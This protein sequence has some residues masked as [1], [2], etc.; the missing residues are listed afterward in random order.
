MN[1]KETLHD[2]STFVLVMLGANRQQAITSAKVD[3][4][5]CRHVSSLG[6]DKLIKWHCMDT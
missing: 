2:T 1:D 6:H 3:T 5:I 4:D